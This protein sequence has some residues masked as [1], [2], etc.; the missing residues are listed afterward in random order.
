MKAYDSVH[1]FILDESFV[2]YHF[3]KNVADVLI[4]EQYLHDHPEQAQLIAEARRMLHT[5]HSAL[6]EIDAHKNYMVLQ[7]TL[8]ARRR[9]KFTYPKVYYAAASIA[10]IVLSALSI[11][12]F[13]M[14]STA[15][16]IHV[17]KPSERKIIE[18]ADGTLIM[19]NAD[20]R[21]SI[22]EGYG[23][24][25]RNITL[26]GEAYM[27]VAKNPE[28][29]FSV[30][31][32]ALDVNVLGTTINV[33]AYDNEEVAAA[34]LIEG[35]AEVVLKNGTSKPILLKPK[36]KVV[37]LSKSKIT[38]DEGS[39]TSKLKQND[40]SLE[41]VT[42]YDAEQTLAETSWTEQK[43]IFVNE[44]LSSI[45]KTLERWYD[46][47]IEFNNDAIQNRRYTA[48]FDENEQLQSVLES[49]TLSQPFSYKKTDSR[50]IT[51]LSK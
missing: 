29:P 25:N 14:R 21:I 22:A 32:S 35:S 42:H 26:V 5:M 45:A 36:D 43:L 46:V 49:L 12:F 47:K 48:A 37:T 8:Q 40:Y 27:Q 39:I 13:V 9:K 10:L 16:L 41:S 24:S 19:L 31:T 38:A 3:R 1:D 15:D 33:R 28:L 44:P 30:K 4:W 11:W 51:I 23:K 17:T 7:Q 34:S 6:A 50:T 2:H 20:S 18:L